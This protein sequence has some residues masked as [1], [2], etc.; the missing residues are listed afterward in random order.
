[1]RRR[2]GTAIYSSVLRDE[3]ERGT[4]HAS[5]HA[6]DPERQDAERSVRLV[7]RSVGDRHPPLSDK[8]GFSKQGPLSHVDSTADRFLSPRPIT[9]HLAVSQGLSHTA[10]AL[11]YPKHKDGGPL[12]WLAPLR[13]RSVTSVRGGSRPSR[14]G[15]RRLRPDR[16]ASNHNE[17]YPCSTGMR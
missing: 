12:F 13:N 15:S 2:V 7:R 17:E 4:H 3:L 9:I 14:R 10:R 8:R 5:D 6:V 16:P 11:G 1:M